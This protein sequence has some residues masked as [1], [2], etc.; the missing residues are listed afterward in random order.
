[1]IKEIANSM[2][3]A[4]AAPLFSNTLVKAPA[5]E[6]IITQTTNPLHNS[7]A[8]LLKLAMP[9]ARSSVCLETLENQRR[10]RSSLRNLSRS[11]DDSTYS[12]ATLVCA[13]LQIS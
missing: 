10:D 6:S 4:S 7:K 1:V 5:S 2:I 3:Q 13:S 12:S 11:S 9:V 8:S